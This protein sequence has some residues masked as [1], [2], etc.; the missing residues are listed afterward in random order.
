MKKNLSTVIVL[1]G[2]SLLIAGSTLQA[3]RGADIN[4]SPV[5]I[6]QPQ[7]EVNPWADKGIASNYAFGAYY[8]RKHVDEKWHLDSRTDQWSDIMVKF[9]NG[10]QEL[11]FW[12]GSS[13]LPYWNTGKGKYD[14]K[15]IVKRSG[16]GS[17]KQ[18][19]K[20][21]RYSRARVIESTDKR[22]VIHWRYMP[23]FT[24]NVGPN[25]MPDQ[26]RMVDEYF[27]I[28]PDRSVVRAVLEGQSRY[29]DWRSSAPGKLFRYM[30]TDKGAEEKSA[31]SADRKLMLDVMG[32]SNEKAH[33]MKPVPVIAY[34]DNLPAPIVRFN[35]D[36]GK[37]LITTEA[38]SGDKLNIQGHAA[39]WRGGV[40]GT[41]L[42]FDGWTS[43]VEQNEKD[44]SDKVKDKITLDAWISIAAYPWNTCPIIQQ[45]QEEDDR[46]HK[47]VMLPKQTKGVMLAMEA[48]GKP[49][50]WLMINGKPITIKAEDALI[51]RFRWTRLTAVIDTS[52]NIGKVMLYIDGKVVAEKTDLTGKLELANGQPIRVGQGIKRLPY[53]PVGRGQYPA[54]YSFE[55]LIDEVSVY[56]AALTSEQI[57][58]D[59]VALKMT[60]ARR[61]KPDMIRRVLPA[62][63]KTWDDFSARY[64][65][66]PF[67]ESWNKMFRM[68]GHPDIV[69]S[70][71]K[72]PARYVLWHGVGYIPMMVSENGRW[73]SNE[74]NENWWDGCCE[75]MSDKKMVFGRV[76]IIEQS[77]ARVVLK[78]RYPLATVGYEI[79]YEN[80]ETR[81]GNWS[82]WYITIYPDGNIVKRMRVYQAKARRHE[83]HESMAIMGPEQ[84][85]EMVVDTTPALTLAT[86]EGEIREYSWINK[87][88]TGVNYENVI[89]HIV[90]MKAQFNPYTIAKDIRKGNVYKSRGG[91]G[92]SAFPAWNHWPVGQ[93]PS[94]GR[95]ATFPDRT[96]HSSLTHIYWPSSSDWG[97][98][99]LFEEKILLEGSSN[100]SAKELLPLAKS[101]QRPPS[102][103]AGQ[104]AEAKY[105]ID[106]RAYV[107]TRDSGNVKAITAKLAGSKDSPIVNPAFVVENWGSDKLAMITSSV[108]SSDIRQ[109]IVRRAN[110][111]NALVV[112]MEMNATKPVEVVIM[113]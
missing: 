92:Y 75:P 65:H 10:P 48:D 67:H 111:V 58:K 78:W 85:P 23:T 40:S 13:Y 55:G 6:N 60:D 89:L 94:D 39:H 108:K 12:R 15:E 47:G 14:L 81:W 62:G 109:G 80:P 18:P 27:V 20:V 73:Y 16:D 107:L 17:D 9:G 5:Y 102:V 1:V 31:Q 45:V 103:T 82:T 70:F 29:E 56:P 100:K 95:H 52:D 113:Q 87:P 43:Q 8:T 38:V 106:Q 26:T 69:V 91:T 97:E 28:Y 61:E 63:E 21:N 105:D 57:N 32:F 44:L 19:D 11:V 49:S 22:A 112:W 72:N 33:Q 98:I 66:L 86:G 41:A 77:P 90:N 34:S 79:S 53:L 64:A 83:W 68:S 96:A 76:H 36:E 7:P 99:G 42:M 51:P 104:G 24:T 71:D 59:A 30:L 101:W 37:G 46:L 110:G 50:L 25:N 93:F 54:H 88:P 74:F 4:K 84:T 2:L 35:F 3:R